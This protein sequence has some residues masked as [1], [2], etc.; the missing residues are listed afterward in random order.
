MAHFGSLCL[1]YHR[2]PDSV[3]NIYFFSPQPKQ[4]IRQYSLESTLSCDANSKWRSMDLNTKAVKGLIISTHDQ[5]KIKLLGIWFNTRIFT[6]VYF[7]PGATRLVCHHSV[8]PTL[9]AWSEAEWVSYLISP[10]L[11]PFVIGSG[12]RHPVMIPS[13]WWLVPWS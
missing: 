5:K 13:F 8:R 11:P 4:I 2:S 12:A 7:M 1:W 9:A 10:P 6:C 3:F